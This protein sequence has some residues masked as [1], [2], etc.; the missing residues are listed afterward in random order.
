MRW[1]TRRWVRII[2][3]ES[4]VAGKTVSLFG[5]EKMSSAPW[6]TDSKMKNKH[7]NKKINK[8]NRL[9]SQE[10]ISKKS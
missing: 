5:W 3:R 1:A 2:I 10:V 9:A 6:T 4:F 7:I 8:K